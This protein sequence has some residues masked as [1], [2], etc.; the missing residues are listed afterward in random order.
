MGKLDLAEESLLKAI[1]SMRLTGVV[2]DHL[3][4]LYFRKGNR[5]QA[6]EFWK[7]ALEQDDDELEKSEVAQKIDRAKTIP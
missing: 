5:D 2:Y 6:V 1:G 4:D 3:G 7:K